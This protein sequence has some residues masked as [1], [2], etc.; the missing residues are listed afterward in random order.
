MG[1]PVLLLRELYYN[2]RTLA[3]CR[4]QPIRIET[5]ESGKRLRPAMPGSPCFFWGRTT[6][7]ARGPGLAQQ[8]VHRRRVLALE[9]RFEFETLPVSPD[10]Q[11]R[12]N[13]SAQP[14]QHRGISFIEA[15]DH[16]GLCFAAGV[17]NIVECDVVVLTPE[18]GDVIE[19]P[20]EA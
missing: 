8:R 18:E 13:F 15:A 10:R 6:A 4:E 7:S 19:G 2:C 3:F 9:R 1:G 12:G 14:V 5:G 16:F 20:A 17:T 11:H